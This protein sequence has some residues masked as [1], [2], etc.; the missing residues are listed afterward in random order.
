LRAT[1]LLLAG[2]FAA[3]AGRRLPASVGEPLLRCAEAFAWRGAAA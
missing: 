3:P 2:F 1:D